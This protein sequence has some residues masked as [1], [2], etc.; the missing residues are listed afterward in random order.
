MVAF[1]AGVMEANLTAHLME[2]HWQNIESNFACDGDYH[3]CGDVLEFVYKNGLYIGHVDKDD[4]DSRWYQVRIKILQVQL[5][6]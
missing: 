1:L 2:Q 6:T 3:L 4:S 5:K